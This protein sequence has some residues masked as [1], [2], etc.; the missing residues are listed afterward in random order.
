ME[1][2]HCAERIVGTMHLGRQSAKLDDFCGFF[3]IKEDT[4]KH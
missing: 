2:E 1:T 3:S 4:L